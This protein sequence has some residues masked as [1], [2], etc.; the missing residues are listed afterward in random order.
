MIVHIVDKELFQDV[1]REG[2]RSRSE[3]FTLHRLK[4]Q[5]KNNLDTTAVNLRIGVVVPKRFAKRA[6]RR[7][8]IK[9][10]VYALAQTL[11]LK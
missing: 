8:A 2:V 3:H 6:V 1:L 10:Q 4:A 7:N 5:I 11:A 9:R